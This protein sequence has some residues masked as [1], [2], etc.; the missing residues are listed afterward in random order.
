MPKKPVGICTHMLQITS[1][2]ACNIKLGVVG[3]ATKCLRVDN[4]RSKFLRSPSSFIEQPQSHNPMN[5]VERMLCNTKQRRT[6]GLANWQK[7]YP[8]EI[9]HLNATRSAIRGQH[10]SYMA[11]VLIRQ[12]TSD[13]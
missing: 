3:E 6:N 9:D 7:V 4:T 12:R 11:T 8:P 5:V 10:G 2:H 13:S 1:K